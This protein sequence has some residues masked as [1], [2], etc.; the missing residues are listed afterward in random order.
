MVVFRLLIL[1]LFRLF[2]I[3]LVCLGISFGFRQFR[4]RIVSIRRHLSIGGNVHFIRFNLRYFCI[5][6]QFSINGI[7]LFL[8]ESI[9]KISKRMNAALFRTNTHRT[10]EHILQDTFTRTTHL[11]HLADNFTTGM[12][13]STLILRRRHFTGLIVAADTPQITNGFSEIGKHLCRCHFGKAPHRCRIYIIF[14]IDAVF[15]KAFDRPT[16]NAVLNKVTGTHITIAM[17]LLFRFSLRPCTIFLRCILIRIYNS[18]NV[19]FIKVFF[20]NFL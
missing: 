10:Q 14:F 13:H 6:I 11:Q 7:N 12:A 5:R 9:Y 16:T 17:F 18:F 4:I 19:L 2:V 3:G 20:K 15:D 1:C 8:A